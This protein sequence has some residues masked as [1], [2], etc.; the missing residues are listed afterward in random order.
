ML[1]LPIA[2]R[3]GGSLVPSV[4]VIPS[5]LLGDFAQIPAGSF[6]MGSPETEANRSSDETQHQVT[7]TQ[8]FQMMKTEVTQKMWV[9]IMSSNPSYFKGDNLPVEKVSWNDVQAFIQ[10][11]NQKNDGYT[12]RLPTE[13]Q[14]E[15]AARAGTSTTYSFGDNAAVLGDYG[16]FSGNSGNKTHEVG[17][18]NPNAFGLYDMHGNVWEWVQDWYDISYYSSSNVTDPIG[19][20]SGSDRVVRGGSWINRAKSLRSA[21]RYNYGPDDRYSN[22]GFRLVRTKSH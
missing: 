8:D 12:Y 16:W 13:A 14:W 18:K 20:T 22:V 5:D 6:M 11:L 1:S 7:L 19:P 17:Q 4:D 15:Y 3:A 2:S 10:K 9:S 21:I